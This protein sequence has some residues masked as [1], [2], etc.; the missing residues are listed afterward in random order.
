MLTN[1]YAFASYKVEVTIFP[2][3]PTKKV[4]VID[5][6]LGLQL[7]CIGS[8]DSKHMRRSVF[9]EICQTGGLENTMIQ[10]PECNLLYILP[11]GCV[12]TVPA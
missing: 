7:C 3:T 2:I 9:T 4:R 5:E 6:K 8:S 11:R 1:E 10:C 12:G